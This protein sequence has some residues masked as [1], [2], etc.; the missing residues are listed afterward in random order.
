MASCEHGNGPFGFIKCG[1]F[2]NCLS[3]YQLLKKDSARKE[4]VSWLDR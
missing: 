4:S 3:N 2:I 1:E